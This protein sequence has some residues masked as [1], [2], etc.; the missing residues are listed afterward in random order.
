MDQA[1]KTILVREWIIFALS[2]G[3]GGHVALGLVLHDPSY[4]QDMGWNTVFIGLFLYVLFQALR[5]V[6][7]A[8]R[9]RRVKPDS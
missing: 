7:L 1:R 9:S 4:T 5:S 6:Y 8:I 3:L 2:I